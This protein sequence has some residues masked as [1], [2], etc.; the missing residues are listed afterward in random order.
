MRPFL[1][2]AFIVCGVAAFGQQGNC[3]GGVCPLPQAM[4]RVAKVVSQPVKSVRQVATQPVRKVFA[5]RPV[6]GLLKKVFCR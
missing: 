6:R 4:P 1:F 2:A 5:N 3:P